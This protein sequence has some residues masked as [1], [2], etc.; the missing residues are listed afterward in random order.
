V[1][2]G[3]KNNL[4]TKRLWQDGDLPEPFE[5]LDEDNFSNGQ[6]SAILPGQPVKLGTNVPAWLVEK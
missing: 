6:R 1:S 2:R 5:L 4:E 3:E